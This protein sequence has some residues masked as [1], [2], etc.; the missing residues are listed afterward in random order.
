MNEVELVL[1]IPLKMIE[2]YFLFWTGTRSDNHHLDNRMIQR[3]T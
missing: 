3:N 1:K 2:S